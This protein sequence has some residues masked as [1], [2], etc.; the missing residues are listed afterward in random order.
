MKQVNQY[1]TREELLEALWDEVAFVDDNTLTVNVK[2]VRKKLEELGIKNAI[3]TKRG[4]GYA[5]LRSG[6]KGMKVKNY[7]IIAFL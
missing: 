7:L 6:A 3:V 4:Y 1:V 2:R 5:L